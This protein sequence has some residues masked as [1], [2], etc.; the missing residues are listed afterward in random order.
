MPIQRLNPEGMHSNPAFSQ[1]IILPA[2]ARTVLIGGQNAVDAQGQIVGK[3]DIGQQSAKAVDNLIRVLDA[4]GTDLDH[5]VKV[6]IFI[7]GDA[8]LQPAFGAWMARWG[9]R[10]NPP[11]VTGVRVHGLAHPDFLIEVEAMAVLP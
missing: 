9:N 2:G 4:A 3:G 11:V 8:D 1:G 7:V 5:L 10:S 6:S